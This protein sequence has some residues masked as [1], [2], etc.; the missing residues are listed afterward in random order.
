MIVSARAERPAHRTKRAC[1]PQECSLAAGLRPAGLLVG[2]GECVL[3]PCAFWS[4]PSSST[5]L[6]RT[7]VT[8]VTFSTQ[9]SHAEVS[10]CSTYKNFWTGTSLTSLSPRHLSA[11]EE[12][13][14]LPCTVAT[15]VTPRPGQLCARRPRPAGVRAK[16]R[17]VARQGACGSLDLVRNPRVASKARCDHIATRGAVP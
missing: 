11:S 4:L 16:R 7:R 6:W 13:R 9:T 5:S 10:T 17:Q 2:N 8:L 1:G 14:V 12:L 15:P 3:L